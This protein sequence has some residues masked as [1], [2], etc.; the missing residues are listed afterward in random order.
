MSAD[1]YTPSRDELNGLRAERAKAVAE[2]LDGAPEPT[3]PKAQYDEAIAKVEK[4]QAELEA[5]KRSHAMLET[6]IRVLRV[7]PL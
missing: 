6:T 1:R 2:K 7:S 4:L 3:V 5:V